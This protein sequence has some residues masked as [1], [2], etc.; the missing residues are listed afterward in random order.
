MHSVIYESGARSYKGQPVIAWHIYYLLLHL[1][2]SAIYYYYYLLL[3]I[4]STTATT[5]YYYYILPLSTIG[6]SYVDITLIS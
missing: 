6:V 4:V 2:L 5:T 3:L 1:L